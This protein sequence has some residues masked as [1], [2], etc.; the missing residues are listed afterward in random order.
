[1]NDVPPA[2]PVG[3]RLQR[4]QQDRGLPVALAAEAVAVGHQPL[5][6]QAGQLPQPA[7]VLEVRGERAEAAGVEEVPQAELD[8]GGVAQRVVPLPAGAQLGV[9]RGRC[10]SYSLD[11]LVDLRVGDGVDRRRPGR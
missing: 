1:M 10:P 8:P 7:E 5:H 6:G 3:H 2:S 11:Q 9:R 4:A